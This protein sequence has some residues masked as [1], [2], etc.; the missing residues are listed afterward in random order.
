[1]KTPRNPS[2]SDPPQ[3]HAAPPISRIILYV[4][5]FAGVAAFYQKHFGMRPVGVA[6]EGWFELSSPSGGGIALHKAARSQKSGAA[7][8]VVFGV[9]DVEA[10]RDRCAREGLEFGPIHRVG[11]IM[12][13]NAKDPAGNSISISNRGLT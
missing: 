3:G 13:A 11:G 5:D 1:M 2:P 10:F 9:V 8:K 7:M 4:R 6:G 12:F